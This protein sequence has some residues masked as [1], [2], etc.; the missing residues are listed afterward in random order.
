MQPG[1]VPRGPAAVIPARTSAPIHAAR[2]RQGDPDPAACA[3]PRRERQSQTP[4]TITRC[5][6]RSSSSTTRSA[7]EPRGDRPAPVVHA[8]AV[9]R[10]CST[11]L[12]PRARS[13][14]P[15]DRTARRTARVH[16][17]RAAG[18][19]VAAGQAGLAGRDHARTGRRGWY[20]PSPTPGRA[21][22]V[23]DQ[24]EAPRGVRPPRAGSVTS[25]TW[26]PS[27]ISSTYASASS[28]AHR[29][30]GR[31]AGRI[32]PI[33][34]NRCVAS[35]GAGREARPGPG[36]RSHRCDRSRRRRRPRRRPRSARAPRAAPARRSRCV[37]SPGPRRAT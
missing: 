11:P 2:P 6:C 18:E 36:R 9:A 28:A 17:Q 27:L 13:A 15:A 29:R 4:C 25:C 5:T 7:C 23:G 3:D 26:T 35:R 14:R 1:D 16:R 8:P 10:G 21:D 22:R 20:S 32:E 37:P 33:A 24:R 30:A 31:R 12:R 34:L 19:P